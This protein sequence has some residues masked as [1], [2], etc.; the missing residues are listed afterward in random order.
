MTEDRYELYYWPMIQGRGEFVRLVLEDADQAY[1][2][3]ARLPENEGG[4]MPALRRALSEAP[5]AFAPP[6]L[7]YDGTWISQTTNICAFLAARHGRMPAGEG[8]ERLASHLAATVYDFATEIHNVHH[9]LGSS[10]YYEDQKAEALRAAAAFLG[11][12]L[13]KFLG[14][15]ERCIEQ[16]AAAEPW[17][18][19]NALSYPDLWL[20]Q[21]VEGLCYAFP[22]AMAARLPTHA[23]IARAR[24]A[25]RTRPRLAAY[26]A[27]ERRIA[28][29]EHGLF[30][31]YPELDVD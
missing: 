5:L 27:S 30:R 24:E 4:G 11:H 6:I 10:L 20:F 19:G 16:N 7:K 18:L 21:I 3:V 8:A 13:A 23:K 17:L 9:P 14:F 1:V 26:L 12:R 31:H 28:F 29:N 22:K 25:V 2:D 15:F